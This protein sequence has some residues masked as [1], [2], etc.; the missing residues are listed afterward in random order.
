MTRMR[1]VDF[2]PAR[3]CRLPALAPYIPWL[4]RAAQAGPDWPEVDC[5]RDLF[6]TEVRFVAPQRRLKAGLDASDIDD[7]Y[8]GR[9]VGGHVPTR[10]GNLHDFMNA[11]TWAR[12]PKAKMAHCRRQVAFAKARGRHTNRLRTAEQDRLA[13]I[14][15]GGILQAKDQPA[16]C[17]G[18]GLLE[19]AVFGRFSF[20]FRLRVDSLEDSAIAHI[21]EK[22]PTREWTRERI[23][24][25]A[26]PEP[27]GAHHRVSPFHAVQIENRA[28]RD[29]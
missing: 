13:M 23:P 11:L 20:G 10:R 8:L 16:I 9:C 6:E 18:H 26:P 19:D 21:L 15:E 25:V 28:G 2:E 14:D 17:F 7:S 24:F 3:W 27:Q 4:E 1:E 22:V 29:R 5:Y 12:F